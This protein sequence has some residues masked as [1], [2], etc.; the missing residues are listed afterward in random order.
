MKYV[1]PAV[2][3]WHESEKVYTVKFPDLENCFTDGSDLAEAMDC[4]ADVL[5]L[6][7]WDAEECGDILPEAS[8]AKDI[9]LKDKN[10]F[11]QYVYADTERYKE[12]LQLRK[13][14]TAKKMN[15]AKK[16]TRTRK[17]TEVNL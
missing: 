8:K 16:F 12:F 4:A 15:R 2:F 3:T 13:I 17:G 14:L 5:N 11:V 7:L 10:S 1:Y 6:M 9:A